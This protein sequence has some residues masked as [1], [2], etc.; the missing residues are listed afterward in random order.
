M[1]AVARVLEE[2]APW[3]NDIGGLDAIVAAVGFPVRQ[4]ATLSRADRDEI[5]D[6]IERRAS[7]LIDPADPDCPSP[8]F[9]AEFE[10]FKQLPVE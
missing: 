5:V 8:D 1:T 7:Y 2:C 10:A 9:P 6:Y 3:M 4:K